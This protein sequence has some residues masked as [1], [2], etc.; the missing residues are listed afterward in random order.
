MTPAISV[1]TANVADIAAIVSIEALS[2]SVTWAPSGFLEELSKNNSLNLIAEERLSLAV[3][4]LLSECV[5]D[6]C[7]INT[8]AVSPAFRRRGIAKKLIESLFSIAKQRGIVSIHLEVRSKNLAAIAL[9]NAMGFCSCGVRKA[10][11][12]DTGEDALL[13]C[14]KEPQCL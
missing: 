3:G 12:N 11:Y 5:L 7:C 2:K 9:Y 10:Y 6:E 14:H 4:F 1:R 13:M 8:I